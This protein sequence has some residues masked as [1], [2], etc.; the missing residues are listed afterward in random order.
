[1]GSS[2]DEWSLRPRS[3]AFVRQEG[4]MKDPTGTRESRPGSRE[5]VTPAWSTEAT[6]QLPSSAWIAQHGLKRQRLSLR[7]VLAR[8]GFRQRE[9]FEPSLGRLVS[10]RYGEGRFL[11]Y[12]RRDGTLYRLTVSRAELESLA[13]AV[14]RCEQ[15]YRERLLW[16]GSGSRRAFGV[17]HE[18]S[19]ALVLYDGGGGGIDVGGTGD[20]EGGAHEGRF[21]ALRQALVLLVQEQ[22]AQMERFNVIR[23]GDT[24]EAWQERAVSVTP[25]SLLSA[26]SWLRSLEAQAVPCGGTACAEALTHALGDPSVE[27]V[28][29]VVAGPVEG[30][31]RE[32][33]RKAV[34]TAG[35]PVHVACVDAAAPSASRDFLREIA[36]LTGGRFHTCVLTSCAQSV[37]LARDTAVSA[38]RPRSSQQCV[39]VQQ[40]V[41]EVWKEKEEASQILGEI[42]LILREISAPSATS[43]PS[44]TSAAS[45][46][47]PSRSACQKSW[48][49]VPYNRCDAATTSAV[50]TYATAAA[51]DDGDSWSEDCASVRSDEAEQ[52]SRA[53]LARYGLEARGL[54]LHTALGRCAF[55]HADGVVDSAHGDCGRRRRVL[56]NARYCSCFVHTLWADGALVHV[57]VPERVYRDYAV[58][59]TAALRL[60][61]SRLEWLQRGSRVLFG[62]IVEDRVYVLID[63]SL[64]MEDKLDLLKEKLY[65]LID[66]QLR[67]KSGFNLVRFGSRAGA[68]RRQIVDTTESHLDDA[69]AW[70]ESLEAG[71]ST[72]TLGALRLALGDPATEGVYLLSD[73]RPDQPPRTV[74]SHVRYDP[75]VPVHTVSFCCEDA[76]AADFLHS[77]AS[78]TGGRYHVYPPGGAPHTP[79]PAANGD[80]DD[81]EPYA[82]EPAQDGLP[83]PYT[84]EDVRLLEEELARGARDLERA[85]ALR[86]ECVLLDCYHNG[87]RTRPENSRGSASPDCGQGRNRH[88]QGHPPHTRDTMC[89]GSA[90]P[91]PPPRRPSPQELAHRKHKWRN[92]A[93]EELATNRGLYPAHTRSSLLRALHGAAGGSEVKAAGSRAALPEPQWLLPESGRLLD[94]N[95]RKEA[96]ALGE[97]MEEKSTTPKSKKKTSKDW[98]A[99]NSL[100][101]KRLTIMDALQPTALPVSATYVPILGKNVHSKVFNEIMP[102]AFESHGGARVQLVNPLAV[103]LTAYEARLTK[104]IETYEKH[105]DAMV[106]QA[107]PEKQKERFAQG[108]RAPSFVAR[109]GELLAALEA[110]GWPVTQAAIAR[111]EREAEAA[112]AHL[113]KAR[114]L[115]RAATQLA[116]GG[117][118]RARPRTCPRLAATATAMAR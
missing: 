115:R 96:V 105:L 45:P 116:K 15:L 31:F 69:R 113:E 92:F 72:D 91:Q 28:C 49:C 2:S 44:T 74:L 48:P 79:P 39:G 55:R 100:V 73:G 1:M 81:D 106:F 103:N 11:E 84:S 93:L 46:Q 65:L 22:L 66:E 88:P 27:A 32:L 83:R 61:Q 71:G 7:H 53:W 89:W 29:L 59:L 41:W 21:R 4:E 76:T 17:F 18:R 35:R 3:R 97:L 5:G 63:T 80:S 86:A 95:L 37:S 34:R 10:S 52:S 26:S 54:A 112:R 67:Y 62:S 25:R 47:R 57:Y 9:D 70:V 42:R 50:T 110:A 38:S 114:E 40:D 51:A 111:V 13:E 43:G 108:G 104:Q 23:A 12:C 87:L 6:L 98:L 60:I 14:W 77:L 56:V 117:P 101:A 33:L 75:P 78:D 19:I 20:A 64:S 24:L 118:H 90:P 109:R 36:D 94:T 102:L 99:R 107:L 68:W 8:I 82:G 58:R 85:G 30:V 16:L